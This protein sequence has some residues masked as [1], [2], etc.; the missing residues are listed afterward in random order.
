M[1]LLP[2]LSVVRTAQAR[3]QDDTLGEARPISHFQDLKAWVLLGDPGSGKTS[4][5]EALAASQG[6]APISARD[7]IDF[8]PPHGGYPAPIY[9]DGLDEYTAGSGDGYTAIG[10]IRSRLQAL[11]TPA[12]RLSCREA[13]WRGNSDSAALQQLVGADPFAEL[14]LAPLEDEQILQFAA[15]WLKSSEAQAQTFVTEARRRDLD[16]LLTNPQT[17]RMLIDAVVG[18]ADDW[19][20]SKRETY[21]KACTKLVREQNEAHL[22][23]QRDKSHTDVQLLNAAGYLCA[24]MLLSGSTAIALKAKAQQQPHTLEIAALITDSEQTPSLNACRAALHTHLF[25]GNGMGN[26]TVVHRTVAEYLGAQFLAA[27]IHA[28]LPANRVLALIQGEDGG[29]VPELRGLHAWLA[30]VANEGVRRILID[31]DPLGL[32]LHGDVLGFRTEEKVRL[33]QALQREAS[34]YAHFRSQNWAS[35]PFG[36]LA[37]PDM[38]EHFKTWLQSP[39]RNPAHQAVL[40]CVLDAM[41]HGQPMPALAGNLERIVGDKTYWSGLRRSALHA[42]C[43]GA[44]GAGDWTAPQR[45]LE[46]LRQEKISDEDNDLMGVLLHKLYPKIIH[47]QDL[48][49]YYKP[50]SSTHINGYWEFWRYLAARY[51]PRDDIPLLIDGLLATGIRLHSAA[52]EHDLSEMIGALLQEAIVHFAEDTKAATA[53]AWLS[54]GMGSYSDNR[55]PEK[56]QSAIR[57]WFALHPLQYRRLVEHGITV[58]EKSDQPPHMWLYEIHNLMC[59]APRP[60]EAAK[61]YWELAETRTDAFHQQLVQ[62]A[63][64]LTKEREGTDAALESISL[65]LQ[66]H[67]EDSERVL[68]G[69]LSCPYPPDADQHKWIESGIA[70]KKEKSQ[71]ATEELVFLSQALPKLNSDNAH[72]GLLNHIGEAY[73]DFY[74]HADA[75]TPNER[76]LKKLHNNAHWVQMALAGLRHC[77]RVRDDLPSVADILALL[78][79]QRRY[80]IATPLIAAMQ[81]RYDEKPSTAFNLDQSLLQTL[82]AFR[83]TNNYGNTPAWFSAL[84]QAKPTLVG[85]IMQRIMAQQIAAKVEHVDG[86]YALA[87]DTNYAPIAQLIAPALIETLPTKIGKKQTGIVRELIACLLHT[88]DTSQQLTLIGK[89]LARPAMDVAQYVYWLTAGVQIAPATYLLPLQ[90]YLG[91]NQTRAA[92][93]YELLRE[94]RKEHDSVDRLTLEAKAFFIELMGARL[95]PSEEPRSGKA[96]MV[97]PAMESMRF[98]QQLIAVIAADPAEAA[99]QTLEKLGQSVALKPWSTQLKHAIYE[100]QLLRR[101]ALFKHASVAEV[102]NTLANLQPANAADLHALVLDHLNELAHDIRHS[103]T[104]NY[105][106][107]WD[108]NT[109]KVE[110]SCRNVLLSHLKTRLNLLGVTAEQE[111]TYADQKRADIKISCGALHIPIEIKGNRNKDLW[112]AIPEQLIAKYS[113]EHASAG[114]GIYT[115]FWFGGNNMPTAGDGGNKPKTPQELQERLT[116]TIPLEFARKVAVL[117]IDCSFPANK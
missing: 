30:V 4:T 66:L 117:I 80:T 91:T 96:Y 44:D 22:D 23:A 51:A 81:L 61:W 104:D 40:D 25:V 90:Q 77:L 95:T 46:A 111:G 5:L 103:S 100:Q 2:L 17:L 48:W 84:M 86:L 11:G 32:V 73:V 87:H 47:A 108:G 65:W 88:L 54:L 60:T 3:Q 76:L 69:I 105:D 9:I 38:M 67:P 55:L 63:F 115:I 68:A 28:Y 62:E 112:K 56:T 71:Q 49:T 59:N 39:D 89:R 85:E 27:R 97:T 83:L 8:E 82:V 29:V 33:L 10:R 19:P 116:A 53:Y 58:L 7:F 70:R 1:T 13:D 109:P 98:V 114:Y 110:N 92:Y 34:H 102:C 24:V 93:A 31:H 16:G 79:K 18:T 64:C 57:T 45:L 50:A 113:R 41:E 21:A 12:F 52:N 101:K 75:P 14:H 106:Q 35:Q 42:L 36:A 6:H 99:R 72:M 43:A 78:Q 94:Q 107:Y 26:F 74:H 37:T 20:L 15:H